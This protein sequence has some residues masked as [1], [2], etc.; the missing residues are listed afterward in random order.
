MR[1]PVVFTR[2]YL[3]RPLDTDVVSALVQR[4]AGSDVPRPIAF[5]MQATTEGLAWILGCAETAVQRLKR[6]FRGF[7]PGIQFEAASRADMATVGRV[8]ARP[9]SLP[10]A[11]PDPEDLVAA[12]FQALA[13]RRDD[14]V[15]ALQI[16]IGRAH[17][18][19]QTPPVMPDPLQPIGSLLLDG[20][21]PAP[22]DVRHRVT[23]YEAQIRLE[24]TARIGVTTTTS[25]RKRALIWE[26]FGALGSLESPGVHLTLMR[27][28]SASWKAATLGLGGKLRLTPRQLVPLLGW[29]LGERDYPGVAGVHPKLLPVPEI[30]SRT[31]SVFA[32]GTAPGPERPIGVDPQS[33]LQHLITLGPT[34]SGKSTLLE[35]LVLSDIKAGRACVVIEPKAQ[36]IN[37]ILDITPAEYADRIVVL[38]ATDLDTTVGFNPLDVGDRD[39]DIVVDGILA[40]LS[41]VFEDGWGPRTEYLIQCAL[42]SLARAGQARREPYTLIDLPTFLTDAAFRR[43]VA[44]AVADD[45]TLAAFFAEFEDLRPG[46]RAAMIAAPLN[47]LRKL[48]LRKPLV[49]VLGQSQPRFRLRDVFRDKKTVLVPLNDSL[50]GS[51]ASNLL[52]S[53]I[54]AELWMATLERAREKDPM[55]RPGMVFI[56]EVQNY[57]HLPTKIEDVLSTSRSYG[58]AW[59]L[60]HQYRAQLPATLRK[61]LDANARSKICFALEP[62]DAKDMARLAPELTADD[63]QALPEHSIYARLIAGGTRT[64]WCSA[65][66]LAPAPEA[67]A[68]QLIRDTSRNLYGRIP[69]VE[70]P[71]AAP[72]PTPAT[73]RKPEHDLATPR[74]THQKARRS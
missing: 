47:K 40:A 48:V 63:F 8:M 26:M 10:L 59:H 24:A 57:L 46:Q 18:P 45:P 32:I 29:P 51:G 2:L 30:V 74:R 68:A 55:K 36:L 15:M 53:L 39:P 69:P 50:L 6:L 5:E 38:D 56:D 42:L 72:P 23:S 58:V 1:E 4:L 9:G 22:H 70:A 16:V 3:P 54:V 13:A 43:P 64:S 20:A 25:K 17:G 31:K 61:G 19:A 33:R 11:Q 49:A 44:A 65:H 28:S 27:D 73:G 21:R 62:D 71:H 66:T 67:G 7:I 41:A 35:H 60:A 12:I 34:G 52:G 14:E 37:R